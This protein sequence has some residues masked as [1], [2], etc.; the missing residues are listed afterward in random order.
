MNFIV[1]LGIDCWNFCFGIL[2]LNNKADGTF[3]D[4]F[5]DTRQ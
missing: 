3:V 2:L 4:M 1:N 5:G